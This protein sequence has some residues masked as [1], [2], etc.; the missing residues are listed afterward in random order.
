MWHIRC[1]WL[2]AGLLII[3]SGVALSANID[4][5]SDVYD[6]L[7]KLEAEGIVKSGLLATKPLSRQEVIRLILEA[8]SNAGSS[9]PFIRQVIKS[10]K[11]RFK[12]EIES[13]PFIKPVESP[14]GLYIYADSDVVER[15]TYNNDGDNY[16]KGSNLRFGMASIADFQWF[17]FRID[18][19]IRYSGDDLVFLADKAYGTLGFSG[20][21]IE[22]GKDSQWWGPGYHAALL[23]SNNPEPMTI[24]K[25]S[26]PRPVILPS[27]LK[28]FGLFKFVFFVTR[29]E[30]ERV[31][32]RPYLWGL[33]INLKPT[34]YIE[35]GL[36]R[37]ALLGGEGRSEGL[38]TWLKSFTGKGEN[39]S[40]VEAGDQRAGLD[41]KLTLPF[42]WQPIQFYAE[43]AG[44]DEA[45]GFPSKWAYLAGI[46]LPRILNIERLDFRVEY[47]TTYIKKYPNVWYAHHIYGSGYTYKERIIGHHMGTDSKDIFLEAGYFMPALNNGRVG[48]SYDM[49]RHNLSG[50][51]NETKE[52]V[53][54]RIDLPIK[55]AVIFKTAYSYG[56]LKSVGNIRGI[57]RN[58]N[59]LFTEVAYRF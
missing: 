33:R 37:T 30:K 14:Y 22:I 58:V 7:R 9:S 34:P 50:E 40:G 15:L 29:L 56:K 3:S 36:N 59:V 1:F 44:E 2:I 47:A 23:L 51:V 54:L 45:G 5:K 55:E 48:V 13:E 26:N 27:L 53:T 57:D 16:K 32:S 4:V 18:P 20:L 41:L 17:S 46:Y 11:D 39:E 35:I 12:Y 28:H 31:V 49:E 19:E 43:A 38:E 42:R 8:E 52:E 10:L 6:L 21:E 24:L 25:V